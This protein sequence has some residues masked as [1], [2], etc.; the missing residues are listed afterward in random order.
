MTTSE[1]R[2]ALATLDLSQVKLA[3]ALGVHE[4]TVRRYALGEVVI[5][6]PIAKLLRLAV[7][8]RITVKQIEES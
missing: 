8:G 3:R 6:P 5:P 1:L 7:A 2:A 4:R